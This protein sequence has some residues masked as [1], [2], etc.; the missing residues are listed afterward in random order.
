MSASGQKQT[1]SSARTPMFPMSAFGKADVQAI[2]TPAVFCYSQHAAIL[3]VI[4]AFLDR[5]AFD[6]ERYLGR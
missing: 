1:S 2:L 3:P 4:L 6:T 5:T